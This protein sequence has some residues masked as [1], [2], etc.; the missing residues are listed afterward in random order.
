MEKAQVK[1]SIF[2]MVVQFYGLFK[3][4]N[5]LTV[6]VQIRQDRRAQQQAGGG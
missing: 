5:G 1:P 2:I 3:G 6:P 4:C